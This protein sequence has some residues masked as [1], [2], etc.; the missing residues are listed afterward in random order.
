MGSVSVGLAQG[1][2]HLL[3]DVRFGSDSWILVVAVVPVPK[4]SQS[5]AQRD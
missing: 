2:F 4:P 1:A 5:D 3:G